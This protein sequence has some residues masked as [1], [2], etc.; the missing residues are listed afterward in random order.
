MKRGKM[1][2]NYIK[3]ANWLLENIILILAKEARTY[4]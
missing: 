2:A 1:G 3:R 4:G